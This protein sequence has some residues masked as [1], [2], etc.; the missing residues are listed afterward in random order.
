M[1]ARVLGP[2]IIRIALALLLAALAAAGHAQ[3]AGRSEAPL[4]LA[5]PDLDWA[6]EI[7][8]TGFAVQLD[9]VRPDGNARY[10][11][12]TSDGSALNI[13]VVV[14]KLAASQSPTDCRAH[15]WST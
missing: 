11:R 12:A 1:L 13:S 15:Y 4:S 10:L 9:D 7:P 6:L 3:P 2:M 14:E 5:L 8:A